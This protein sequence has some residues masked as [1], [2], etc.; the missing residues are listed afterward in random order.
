MKVYIAKRYNP[1]VS[2]TLNFLL[3]S[4]L[5]Q[6]L[7]KVLYGEI[8]ASKE[9]TVIA[10][11]FCSYVVYKGLQDEQRRIQEEEDKHD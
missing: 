7:E 6:V 3:L 4:L 10:I 5:W 8:R 11:L 1:L 2:F 9:D